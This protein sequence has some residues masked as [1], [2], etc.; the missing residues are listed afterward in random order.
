[1][2]MSRRK[3]NWNIVLSPNWWAYNWVA[4][5]ISGRAYNRDFTVLVC[6]LIQHLKLVTPTANCVILGPKT[7]HCPLSTI[8]NY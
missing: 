4:G 7:F 3:Y 8:L 2:L 1:M 6:H 5:L